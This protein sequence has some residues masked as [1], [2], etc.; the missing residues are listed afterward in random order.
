MAR[1]GA[2]KHEDIME[3]LE[4]FG[5]QVLPEL[6]ERHKDHQKWREEQLAGVEFEVNSS[7]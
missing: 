5:K 2:R 3:S 4:R 7:I 6:K 1:A